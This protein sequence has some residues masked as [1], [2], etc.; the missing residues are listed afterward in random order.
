MQLVIHRLAINPVQQGKGF[1][2]RLI[3]FAEG[4]ILRMDFKSI[5]LDAF[6][7]NLK[8][9]MLYE[10]MGYQ[11]R[12]EVNFPGRNLPFICFEKILQ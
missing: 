5:R 1:A 4:E 6:S 7:G 3:S 11:K 8:A 10:G 9:L 12:G 2:K